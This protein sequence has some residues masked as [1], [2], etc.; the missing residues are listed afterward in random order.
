LTLAT[1]PIRSVRAVTGAWDPKRRTEGA[2]AA[3]VTLTDGAVAQLTYSGYDHFDTDELHY[4]V[5]ESGDEK[6]GDEHGKARAGLRAVI[7]EPERERQ[8]RAGFGY[9][10]R[11]AMRPAGGG[12]EGH[13]G[14]LLASCE[15]AD[16]RP[17]PDGVTIYADDGVRTIDVP[18]ARIYPNRGPVIDELYEAVVNGVA[19]IHD[20]RWGT[21]SMTAVLALVESARTGNEIFLEEV[22]V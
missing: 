9:A 17:A 21:R 13:F 15:R 7:D 4:W 14:F 8:L 22:A 5:G 20:G 18:K 16:L 6:P 2:M 11:G 1:A 19:P 10:G 12:H 3:F